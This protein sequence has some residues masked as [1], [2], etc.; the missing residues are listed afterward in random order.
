MKFFLFNFLSLFQWYR[1]KI[2]GKWYKIYDA[3][4]DFGLAG[5]TNRWTR[6][7][8]LP[9]IEIIEEENWAL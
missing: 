4:G 3:Q 2:G 9:P 1:K 5:D 7:R 8:P 6:E